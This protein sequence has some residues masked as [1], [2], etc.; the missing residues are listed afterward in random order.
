MKEI[1]GY[2]ELEL[3][4]K[5][6]YHKEA[7]KLNSASNCFKYI[8]ETQNI[9]KVYIPNYICDSI[10]V[11]LVDLKIEYEFYNIDSKFEII[12]DI[13]LKKNEKVFYVNYFGLKN[14]YIEKLFSRYANKLIIDNSQAFFDKPIGGIDTIY[15]PRKFFGVSDGGYLYTNEKL[16]E[17]FEYDISLP[18]SVQLMGRLEKSAAEFYGKYMEAEDRLDNL[19]IRKMSKLTNRILQSLDYELIKHK[20]ERNFFYLHSFLKEF[21]SLN[22]QQIATP[23]VYPFMIDF[24]GLKKFLIDNKIY[25]AT[26]W[27]EVSQ[28]ENINEFEKKFVDNLLPIPC[29]QRY[30]LDDMERIIK[31][32]LGVIKDD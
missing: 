20:R 28:R 18:Y 10:V 7:I 27:N 15:S 31:I 32:I 30:S 23:M 1:G 13:K 5:E 24:Q 25:V 8:L 4:Q 29:D 9:S 21:N 16:D 19:P 6:E 12:L 22:I 26:Y 3:S 14:K 11:P 17:V 2:F